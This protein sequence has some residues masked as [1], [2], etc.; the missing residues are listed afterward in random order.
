MENC[1]I[2]DVRV[3]GGLEVPPLILRDRAGENP[4][5]FRLRGDGADN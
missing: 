3:R 2:I 4:T 5:G 1:I